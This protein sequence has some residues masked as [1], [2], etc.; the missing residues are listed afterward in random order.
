MPSA[1]LVQGSFSDLDLLC[2]DNFARAAKRH[3]VKQIIY[4]GGLLPTTDELSLHLQSR[5]EVERA[6]AATGVPVTTLRAGLVVGANGS[7]FQMLLRLVKRLPMMLCPAW[8][9]TRM[10][11]VAIA[12]GCMRV[13]VHA[14]QSIIG[15]RFTSRSNI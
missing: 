10:Q 3:D 5:A 14:G 12:T 13:F 11:P 9:K 7:S 2:A 6:L 1:R 4:L 15:R 8:T